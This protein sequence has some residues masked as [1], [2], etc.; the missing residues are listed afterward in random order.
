MYLLCSLV[1]LSLSLAV[2]NRAN[3]PPHIL[4]VVADDLGWSDVG[5]HRSK[6]QTRNIDELASEGVILDNYYVMPICTPTRSAL[7]TGMYPIHTGEWPFVSLKILTLK[8]FQQCGSQTPRFLISIFAAVLDFLQRQFRKSVAEPYELDAFVPL[9]SREPLSKEVS[10]YAS[11]LGESR[12]F[13]R[14]EGGRG[15]KI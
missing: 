11:L 4:L 12:F 8:I 9:Y 6:I 14:F 13:S 2:A 5:F 10:D 3:K 1:A 7:L 15:C